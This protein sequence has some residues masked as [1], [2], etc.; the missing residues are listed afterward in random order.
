MIKF[1]AVLACAVCFGDPA[2]PSTKGITAG[3]LLLIGTV[4]FV[5]AAISAVAFRWSRNAKKLDS[6]PQ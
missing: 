6:I 4:G 1:A 3:V 2:D 5:L